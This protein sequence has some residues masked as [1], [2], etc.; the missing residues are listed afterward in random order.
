MSIVSTSIQEATVVNRHMANDADVG[1]SKMRHQDVITENFG[2]ATTGTAVTTTRQ[3][4]V[5]RKT[6]T[7]RDFI[8]TISAAATVG[9]MTID[10]KINGTSV[11]SSAISFVV[12]TQADTPQVATISS[13]AIAV[14][15]VITV[16]S[17]IS[18]GY[19]GTGPFAQLH[20][21]RYYV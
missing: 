7:L 14:G 20:I 10:L 5:A 13:S 6:G 18:G 15:D 9:S 8:A 12:A 4:M 11:L 16:A 19:D 2:L 17:T 21:D 3:I 1:P